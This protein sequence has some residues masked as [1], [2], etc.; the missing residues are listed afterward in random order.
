MTLVGLVHLFVT[1]ARRRLKKQTPELT[2][3]RTV[4]LME[5]ALAEPEL[6]LARATALVS[7]YVQRND[8]ARRYHAKT[9][10]ARNRDVCFL[11]L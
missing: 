2:L 6:K 3:D 7:Y 11:R 5:A 9:W 4:R 1:L 8:V 10:W